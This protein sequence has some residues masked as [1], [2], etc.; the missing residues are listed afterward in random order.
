MTHRLAAISALLVFALC[1]VLGIQAHNSFTT[2]LTRALIAMSCTF[3]L[4]LLIGAAAQKMLD[5][6]LEHEEQKLKQDPGSGA[7]SGSGAAHQ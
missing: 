5:E 4:G 3:I 2:T 1:L 7:A 6:N